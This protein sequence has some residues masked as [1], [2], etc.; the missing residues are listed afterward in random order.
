MKIQ[1]QISDYK[2]GYHK[3]VVV[4]PEEVMKE[5]GFKGGEELKVES[6]KGKLELRRK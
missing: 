4:I 6:E 5:T 1:K 2:R 3:Y